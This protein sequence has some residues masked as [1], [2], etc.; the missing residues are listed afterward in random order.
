M[1]GVI[2]SPIIMRPFSVDFAAAIFVREGGG[3]TIA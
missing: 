1:S 2:M 3:H